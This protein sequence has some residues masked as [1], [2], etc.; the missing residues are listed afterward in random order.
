MEPS[1]K[2]ANP[3]LELDKRAFLSTDSKE[4]EAQTTLP[5]ELLLNGASISHFCL[6]HNSLET[7]YTI[8]AHPHKDK[9]GVVKGE[10]K[11]GKL[12]CVLTKGE[13]KSNKLLN[14]NL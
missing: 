7:K 12:C 13:L 8:P 10:S 3:P 11:N 6:T 5:F 4:F 1:Q 2:Y 14:H 9:V